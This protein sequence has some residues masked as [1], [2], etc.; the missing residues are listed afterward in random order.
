MSGAVILLLFVS[1]RG[2]LSG[3]GAGSVC[4]ESGWLGLLRESGQP[5]GAGCDDDGV[6]QSREP[7][8]GFCSPLTREPS[9]AAFHTACSAV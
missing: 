9:T 8:Q 6:V 1:V 4:P 7:R 5:A 3:C 2:A